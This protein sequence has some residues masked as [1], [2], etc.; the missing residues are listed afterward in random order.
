MTHLRRVAPVSAEALS[1]IDAVLVS[2]LHYDHLD[3]PSLR[4]LGAST[5]ILVPRG[6][7]SLLRR[8]RFEHVSEV[9]VGEEVRV[10]DVTVT[11]TYA[12]HSGSRPPLRVT[13]PALGYVIDDGRTRLY[14]AGDTAVFPGMADLSPGLGIALL[15][16]WGWGPKLGAGHLDPLGAAEALTLLRP[17]IAVPIHW[18][19]YFPFRPAPS[20][21]PTLVP[22]R[23]RRL[24]SP[25]RGRGRSRRRDPRP[26]SRRLLRRRLTRSGGGS[27]STRSALLGAAART[28]RAGT[29]ASR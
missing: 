8:K 6:A 1:A 19:T 21:F 20:L 13:A 26:R 22:Q 18:G 14:F 7:G 9:T 12:D 11:A 5:P 28:K 25:A 17:R 10:G 4:R 16:I 27:A 3:I 15:P 2:H 24:I 23:P 29:R